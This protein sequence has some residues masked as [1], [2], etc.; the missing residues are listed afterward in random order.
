M[1]ESMLRS[2]VCSGFT[3]CRERHEEAIMWRSTV[4]V[5]VTLVLGVLAAPVIATAQQPAKIPRVG[6]LSP[7][8]PA[9]WPDLDA[10]RQGLHDLGYVEGQNLLLEYRYADWQLDRLPTLAAES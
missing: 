4:G 7:A 6:V 3:V 8:P 2:T 9:P 10:F 5:I 1:L